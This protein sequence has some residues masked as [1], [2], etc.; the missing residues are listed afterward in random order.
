METTQLEK[1]ATSTSSTT[2]DVKMVPVTEQITLTGASPFPA[3]ETVQEPV[4]PQIVAPVPTT[5]VEPPSQP[6]QPVAPVL[7]EAQIYQRFKD[8][9][10][11]VHEMINGPVFAMVEELN[12]IKIEIGKKI[13]THPNLEIFRQYYGLKLGEVEDIQTENYAEMLNNITESMTQGLLPLDHFTFQYPWL[14]NNNARGNGVHIT[15]IQ[16]LILKTRL[17]N[18]LANKQSKLYLTYGYDPAL[19]T[20]VKNRYSEIAN[21]KLPQFVHIVG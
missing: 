4:Q 14:D 17:A 21:G 20:R 2:V 8:E 3:P 18:E 12:R 6:P 5:I 13:A 9:K 19:L 11:I 16:L 15:H 1:V 7:T 10:S